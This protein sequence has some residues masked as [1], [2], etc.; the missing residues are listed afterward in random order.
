MERRFETSQR[1]AA[2]TTPYDPER[3]RVAPYTSEAPLFDD[4]AVQHARQAE[5]LPA[6]VSG[7]ARRARSWPPAFALTVIVS[8]LVGGMVGGLVAASFRGG[9][10]VQSTS[11]ADAPRPAA[12]NSSAA[13][14]Q[15]PAAPPADAATA[16]LNEAGPS[17]NVSA[18]P[19]DAVPS[20]DAE[21]SA[22]EVSPEEPAAAP[23]SP[24]GERAA[25]RAELRAALDRWLAATNARDLDRQ[26][27]FYGDR[28]SAFYLT[29]NVTRADV[30]AEKARVFGRAASVSVSA[31][32]PEI[33]V[34][35]DG[36]TAS[37]RF[38]KRYN[39]Q[40]DG[41]ARR[42]EVLQE[43]RWRRSPG[44]WRIVSERDL[45]VLNE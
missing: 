38:R 2:R 44:G 39:I 4:A 16:G 21:A 40:G 1:D 33:T 37:M 9:P 26:L 13:T 35:P 10:V 25:P 15:T 42:G 6:N 34:S 7:R 29:R 8:A 23:A 31:S 24:D 12:L 32:E 5:P 27:N 14:T 3:T 43:L 41:S 36:R 19:P 11:T 18:P 17:S 22:R 45:R 30:R 28:V 20:P